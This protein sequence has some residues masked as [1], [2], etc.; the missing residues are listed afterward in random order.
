MGKAVQQELNSITSKMEG[1][2]PV[3]YPRFPD[4]LLAMFFHTS[5]AN[6]FL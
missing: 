3:E 2:S 5:L 4:L 6:I 1:G